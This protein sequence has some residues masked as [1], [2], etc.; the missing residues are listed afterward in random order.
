MFA[1]LGGL[2]Q[3]LL[4]LIIAMVVFRHRLPD[5]ARWLGKTLVSFR[6]EATN[7]TEEIRNNSR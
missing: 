1:I 3:M 5:V 2:P 6:K 4:I 7:V